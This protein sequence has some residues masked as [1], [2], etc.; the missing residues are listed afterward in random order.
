[1]VIWSNAGISNFDIL[2]ASIFNPAKFFDED[3]I[4]G[5]IEIGKE[6][7]LIMLDENPILEIKNIK[8]INCTIINGN[9]FYK[10]DLLKKI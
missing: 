1:M 7:N 10:T 3:K 6:A 2:K 9:I 5:T 8:T 4:R